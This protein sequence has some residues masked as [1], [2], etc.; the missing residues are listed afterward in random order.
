MSC[1][2]FRSNL[3]HPCG[4]YL[5][6]SCSS[7]LSGPLIIAIFIMLQLGGTHHLPHSR[8]RQQR[9]ATPLIFTRVVKCR[10]AHMHAKRSRIGEAARRMPEYARSYTLCRQTALKASA[11]LHL[12]FEV[13]PGLCVAE[14]PIGG[15]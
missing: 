11:D 5:T 14:M 3:D 4:G 15:I 2:N 9:S 12:L 8:T 1:C 6:R 10:G 7:F 13:N